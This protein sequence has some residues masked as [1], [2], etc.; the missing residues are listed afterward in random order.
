MRYNIS[1]QSDINA[2]KI[3][4]KNQVAIKNKHRNKKDVPV[5][6]KSFKSC[7]ALIPVRPMYNL[8]ATRGS[9]NLKP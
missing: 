4:Q 3:Q 7:T 8:A 1:T 6:D 9:Y 2:V 5:L